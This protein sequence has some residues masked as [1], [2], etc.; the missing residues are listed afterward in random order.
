M[1]S[2]HVDIERAEWISGTVFCGPGAVHE[3]KEIVKVK[4]LSDRRAEGGGS[5]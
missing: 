3:G 1:A 4:R 5:A 2:T